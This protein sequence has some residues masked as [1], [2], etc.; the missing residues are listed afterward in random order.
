MIEPRDVKVFT[1][2]MDQ[3]TEAR[4]LKEGNY[5]YLLNARNAIGTQGSFGAIE[6]VM[7]NSLVTNPN[8]PLGTNKVIGSYEDI[9]GQ[10]CIYFVYNSNG[11]HGIYRWYANRVGFPN[12]VI[13]TIYQILFPGAYST[14]N[15]DP[16]N[17]QID[18]LITGIN[19]VN[20]ELYWTDDYNQPKS[21]N[22]D[23]ANR[24]NKFL[25][26]NLYFNQLELFNSVTYT[27]VVY[28]NNAIL[29]TY[30]FTSNQIF[31]DKRALDLFNQINGANIEFNAEY[32][33]N[34][35]KIKCLAATD[36]IVFSDNAVNKSRLVPD[37][38]YNDLIFLPNVPL[39][40]G[41]Y[42][43]RIKHPPACRPNCSFYPLP[44]VG[45]TLNYA[46]P[47]TLLLN[48][49]YGGNKTQFG[50]WTGNGSALWGLFNTQNGGI[51]I[52]SASTY[53][54]YVQNVTNITGNNYGYITSNQ[55][56]TININ[57]YCNVQNIVNG[58]QNGN[59]TAYLVAIQGNAV[60]Q[61]IQL[62]VAT[63]N[64]SISLDY[65]FT[66][67]FPVAPSTR[68]AILFVATDAVAVINGSISFSAV[69]QTITNNL[70]SQRFL[71]R[72]KYIYRNN[73][74]S[75]YGQSTT[76]VL[77]NQLPDLTLQKYIYIDF[78]DTYISDDNYCSDIKNVV[79]SYSD[80]DG[81]TWY[82]FLKLEPY[83]YAC[84]NNANYYFSNINLGVVVPPTEAVQQ[85]HA[86]PLK[87]K[88][89]E[90]IDNRIFDG[91][92]TE[93]YNNVILNCS[94]DADFVA[95]PQ[96][97][98]T[99][100]LTNWYSF[101]KQG[102]KFGYE[103][104][105][106]IVY[107]DNYDRKTGVNLIGKLSIPY[108]PGIYHTGT[109]LPYL[110]SML[111]VGTTNPPGYYQ[112]KVNILNEAPDWATKY[113]I[114]RSEDTY[115]TNYLIWTPDKVEWLTAD[116]TVTINPASAKYIKIYLD[117]I[118][119]MVNKDFG[120]VVQ[121]T[122]VA[123]DRVRVFSDLSL[124]VIPFCPDAEILASPQS[125]P[126]SIVINY[127][128]AFGTYCKMG[129]LIEIYTPANKKAPDQLF[130]YEMGECYDLGEVKINGILKK[131]H[132]GNIQ[133][134]NLTT[135]APAIISSDNGGVYYGCQEI[136]YN[137][138][139]STTTKVIPYISSLLASDYID[140]VFTGLT[141]P[142][143]VSNTGQLY[144]PSGLRFTDQI[145]FN[146]QINGLNNNQGLN[147]KE[148]NVVYGRINKLQVVNNDILKLIFGN[149]Y[150][151]SIYVSQGVIRQSQG[152]ANLISVSEEVAGNSHII[153][154]TLGT[155]NAESVLTND[156][157]D[158]FGYDENE[159]VVWVG[160]G[161]GLI[162]ISD[163]GMKSIFKRY[164]NERKALGLPS[165]TP[166]VYDLYHDE[167]IITFGT[168]TDP[169]NPANSFAGVTIAYN[170]QK[171]GWTSYYSFVPEYY[172][173]VRD[174]VVSFKDGDLWVHD[175]NQLSKNFYGTQ[176]NR[177]LTY[178]S[179]KD[180]P[181]V[182]DY[183]AVSVNGI[184]AN[185]APTIRILPFQGYL[186]GMLSSLSTRFFQTLEGVQYAYFQKDKLS[187]GFG[188]N[189]LQA[190]ANGRNL[191][192][193]VIEVTLEN[194]D[195]AK[196]IIYSSDII[197]F[198]SEHS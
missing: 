198:Y 174:Y 33:T 140:F 108:Y 159:G 98:N 62:G 106:G 91:C 162:Q 47:T 164:S 175:R 99:T 75:V 168:I 83:Q 118:P 123:G 155:I 1:G 195:T 142:N 196:S 43:N 179:N 3:D 35:L 100:F 2:T 188:G 29:N 8:L 138:S 104:Y 120:R 70:I 77:S 169:N 112:L 32:N 11:Y 187:P 74:Q 17:F 181:K 190:L 165:E 56:E 14:D 151:L 147:E 66:Y 130:F 12:G 30:T 172:G 149:S 185:S 170:K 9:A 94:I 166:A 126:N 182:K 135:S 95:Y 129:S 158:M 150:Q 87:S 85:Y 61:Q 154:R 28:R 152:N 88:S 141:R 63:L 121:Y 192:G 27:F 146:T 40:D 176:Y 76:I 122:F 7:G 22:I 101:R 41:E 71:F 114:V 117:N 18:K 180:F 51:Y 16:L 81:L 10:S 50:N 113:R 163:R 102:W 161:N 137:T 92:I 82:D 178:I 64:N 34:Y 97:S 60:I 160:S 24:T 173:R 183:K 96:A 186:S 44:F 131:Y 25:S 13:E 73:Q 19:L 119:Y 125:T 110:P 116:G 132:K 191:K 189:Q 69:N 90:F 58:N 52:N 57:L 39:V 153:Q 46:V 89:Q 157:A 193:Q 171:N 127:D 80:D 145:M 156:E 109:R 15:P 36:F 67:N 86:V 144:R 38:F 5:R 103:G 65:T 139:V 54:P 133:N 23:R 197:Y 93:G 134:Q 26:Y 167:Y 78:S 79:L 20:D 21:I 136:F 128:T 72:A 53:L 184:G 6:D 148:F 115:T 194:T 37:N 143:I 4:Y 105:I 68:L 31:L 42:F 124:N 48:E 55:S 49:T 45:N 177:Q 107:Y 59:I 84:M 111:G